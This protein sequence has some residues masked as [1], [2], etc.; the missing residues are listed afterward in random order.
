MDKEK[1]NRMTGMYTSIGV[2]AI[3][4]LIFFM[5]LAWVAPDPPIPEYGIELSMGEFLS[6]QQEAVNEQIEETD[7]V[8]EMVKPEEQEIQE[9]AKEQEM[10]EEVVTKE[11]VTT[12]VTEDVNSP[13]LVEEKP[14]EKPVEENKP[15][16]TEEVKVEEK[17][18]AEPVKEEPTIDDRALYKKSD[19]DAKPSSRGASL[20]M[21]GWMWDFKP[22][23]DD[24]STENGKIVFQ[25]T[26]DDEGEIINVRTLEKTVSPIVEK[27]YRDAVMELTFSPTA[28]SRTSAP[29]ST[30][31]ITFII[32]SK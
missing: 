15:V 6:E 8:E 25:I 14:T 29:Q 1:K 31:K 21:S 18:A 23:P 26:V 32:Q 27:I 16:S 19:G 24:N 4:F 5:V 20:D 13:D 9:E 2:H 3:L 28:G 11:A 22:D 17:K 7:P 12:P 30:G 10:Q